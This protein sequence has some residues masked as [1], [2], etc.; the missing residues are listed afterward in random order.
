MKNTL[1]ILI[2]TLFVLC[3]HC[4]YAVSYAFYDDNAYG[5]NET[6]PG[7]SNITYGSNGNIYTR[8]GN[9][10]YGS[11]GSMYTHRGNKIISSDGEIYTKSGNI[12][13]GTNGSVCTTTGNTIFCDQ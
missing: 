3:V 12:T 5:F 13:Y 8:R 6:Y 2:I 1:V 9:T 4:R 11:D 10:T 7:R